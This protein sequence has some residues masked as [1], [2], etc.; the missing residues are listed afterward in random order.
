[1]KLIS[2]SPITL[3][4]TIR[5]KADGTA[6]VE[7]R[8]E[9]EHVDIL[10]LCQAMLGVCANFLQQVQSRNQMLVGQKRQEGED[11]GA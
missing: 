1:M 7:T 2:L 6:Q 3:T 9:P 10:A 11:D 4:I 8:A 5:P